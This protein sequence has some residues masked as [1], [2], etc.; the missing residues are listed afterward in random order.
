M[1]LSQRFHAKGKKSQPIYSPLSDNCEKMLQFTSANGTFA[2][3]ESQKNRTGELPLV[4]VMVFIYG[5]YFMYGAAHHYGP[6]YFMDHDVVL[7]TFNYRVG[8]LGRSS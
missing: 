6:T 5:G 2:N 7:V 3:S 4:P 8:A 1:P